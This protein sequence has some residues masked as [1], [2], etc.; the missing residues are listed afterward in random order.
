M[1]VVKPKPKPTAKPKHAAKPRPNALPVAGPQLLST[2]PDLHY[3]R[4]F[5]YGPQRR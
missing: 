3:V 2:D 4:R 5:T 1:R